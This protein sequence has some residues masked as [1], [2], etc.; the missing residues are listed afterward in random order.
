MNKLLWAAMLLIVMVAL[1]RAESVPPPQPT[2]YYQMVSG[3]VFELR[4]DE[5]VD[6]V[7]PAVNLHLQDGEWRVFVGCP[8]TNNYDTNPTDRR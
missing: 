6:N 5:N 3:E 1:V 2:G 4:C 7:Q 8:D